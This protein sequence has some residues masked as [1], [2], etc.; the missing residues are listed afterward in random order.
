[1]LWGGARHSIRS[2]SQ[3]TRAG[4]R[5]WG[6]LL[7]MRLDKVDQ[8]HILSLDALT[9]IFVV[10]EETLQIILF[11]IAVSSNDNLRI[12]SLVVITILTP[13]LTLLRVEECQPSSRLVL[14]LPF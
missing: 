3:T 10:S 14:W 12:Y 8:I 5:A 11:L 6:V 7:K 1:M 4:E 13:L 2:G 9:N